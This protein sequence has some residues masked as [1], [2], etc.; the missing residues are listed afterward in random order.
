MTYLQ[1]NEVLT[2]LIEDQVKPQTIASAEATHRHSS[3]TLR[4]N[5]K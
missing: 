3:T 5:D 2:A 4:H 1:A